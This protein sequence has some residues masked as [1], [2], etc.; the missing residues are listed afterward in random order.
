[1]KDAEGNIIVAL[2]MG[3]DDAQTQ[4]E[5]VFQ[6]WEQRGVERSHVVVKSTLAQ[7]QS[8]TEFG[9]VQDD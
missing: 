2:E 1:M 4:S 6:W 9:S 5:A 7:A 8:D 3:V